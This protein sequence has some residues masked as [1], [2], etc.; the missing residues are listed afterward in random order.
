METSDNGYVFTAHWFEYNAKNLWER[1]IP[2]VKPQKIL[3]IGSFEGASA[4]Y[5]IDKLG[6]EYPLEIHCIDSWEGGIE[7]QTRGVDMNST[8]KLFHDNLR[9][10][11]A[12][13]PNPVDLVVHKER[14][15]S[16][17]AKLLSA[18]KAGYFDFIYV[19]GS[20]QAPDVL[21]DAVVGFKLLRIGGTMAFDDYLW[22]EPLPGG[23]DPLRMP[24]PAIDAFVNLNLR[25]LQL[26]NAPCIQLY[27][28]KIA[29]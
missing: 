16:A 12:A 2:Q 19:D 5:L 27:V 4:C 14:S 13:S 28:Q 7:H 18:G 8:E 24:K 10:A 15:D 6:P 3:E 20:H 22:A 11:I 9:L 1:L 29:D 17:L 23:K 21:F 26:L 25:K